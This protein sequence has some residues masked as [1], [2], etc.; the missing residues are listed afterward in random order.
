[1]F[2]NTRRGGTIAAD[3]DHVR[4]NDQIVR[5]ARNCVLRCAKLCIE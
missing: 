3:R 2:P 4:G 5:T 1:M